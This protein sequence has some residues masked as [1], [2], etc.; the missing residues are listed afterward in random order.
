MRFASRCSIV[1]LGG[2]LPYDRRAT[3]IPSRAPVRYPAWSLGMSRLVSS[4]RALPFFSR[5]HFRLSSILGLV[6]RTLVA[7]FLLPPRSVSFSFSGSSRFRSVPASVSGEGRKRSRKF[8]CRDVP[9]RSKTRMIYLHGAEGETET[10]WIYSTRE[11]L[12][13]VTSRHGGRN[14]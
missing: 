2:I 6:W 1:A 11:S 7:L 8:I 13:S 4:V 9:P 5:F 10:R 3:I 14:P 12:S